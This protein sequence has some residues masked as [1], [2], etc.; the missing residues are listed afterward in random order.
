[1]Y[2][3][4][5]DCIEELKKQYYRLAK[6]YHSDINGG[7]DEAMKE[8]NAEYSALF[9]KYKDIHRSVKEDSPERVYTADKKT[10]EAPEDFINIIAVLLNMDGLEIEL[11]G[12]WVWIGGNTKEHK[13]SLK[14]LGCKWSQNKQ[15]WS[16]HYPEDRSFNRKPYSMDKIRSVFGSEKYGKD[17]ERKMIAG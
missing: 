7:G 17:E 12:R 16:W 11:C 8:V 13:D 1:M 15:M 10:S 3:K 5:V 4:A 2:F 6:M 14:A 9:G